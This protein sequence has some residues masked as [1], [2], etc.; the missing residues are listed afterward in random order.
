MKRKPIIFTVNNKGGIGKSTSSAFVGDALETLGYS[1]LYLSGDQST[2]IVLKTLQPSTPH[3]Y[4]AEPAE[5]NEGMRIAIDATE[6]VV[7][8]DLPGNSSLDAARY[9]AEYSFEMYRDM[10][11][12]FV[13][14][15]VAVQHKDAVAGGIQ[16]IETFLDN[17]E[18]II[19]ANGMKTPLGAPLDMSKIEGGADLLE[20]AENRIIE[21]P[22]FSHDMLKLY[23][24]HPAV[25]TSYLPDGAMGKK[26]R[27]DR[28]KASPW[29][30]LHLKV[31]RSVAMHAEWLTG[32][33]I[34]KP[35]DQEKEKSSQP[36][37][38][39]A[40]E[41]LK[42]KYSDALTGNQPKAAPTGNTK[43]K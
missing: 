34:P 17:A 24:A 36:T 18:P 39:S 4:I 1:V 20:L 23:T 3:Y 41:R 13:L 40:L 28:I 29:H 2:N 5:M 42:L 22:R 43:A 8:F 38:N 33:A 31:V 14:A 10:G 30:T 35:L 37:A 12:R 16:W 9:F 32:K 6:D 21:V 19:F 25:P 15:I 27:M 7:I 11:V 26:L